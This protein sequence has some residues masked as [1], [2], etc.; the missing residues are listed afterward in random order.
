MAVA[1]GV[2][3]VGLLLLDLLL[4]ISHT[5]DRIMAIKKPIGLAGSVVII[6]L[7]VD[8]LAVGGVYDRIFCMLLGV[9]SY[10]WKS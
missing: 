6:A 5:T 1:I 7:G 2:I 3:C 9:I 4:H 8:S 10:L